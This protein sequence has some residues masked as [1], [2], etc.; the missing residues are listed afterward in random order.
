MNVVHGTPTQQVSEQLS[1]QPFTD[2]LGLTQMRAN[3]WTIAEGAMMKHAHREQE[4]L[5]FVLDGVGQIEI[6][7]EV[8][9]IGERDAIV[10]PA[11]STH[12]VSNTGIGPL[13]FLAIGSP[14]V[15]GDAEQG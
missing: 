9:A 11:G 13:T 4:E 14:N 2:E 5:Y 3:V 1:K 15:A 8:V 12:Q 10:V 7:G 6:D